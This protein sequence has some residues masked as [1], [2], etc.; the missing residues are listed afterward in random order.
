MEGNPGKAGEAVQLRSQARL[1]LLESEAN[2]LMI[3]PRVADA[4]TGVL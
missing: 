2:S 3:E 4:Q 1:A